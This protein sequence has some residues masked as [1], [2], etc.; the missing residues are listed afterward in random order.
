MPGE[1]GI[2]TP[3]PVSYVTGIESRLEGAR[4]PRVSG[5]EKALP[6]T[7]TTQGLIF[8]TGHETTAFSASVVMDAM[9]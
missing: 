5:R 9:L 3:F 7:Q 1:S 4:F 6:A 8:I 2:S